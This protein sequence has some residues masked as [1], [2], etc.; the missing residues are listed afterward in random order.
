M[1]KHAFK[2]QGPI[3]GIT[4]SIGAGKTVVSSILKNKGFAVIN[5]DEVAKDIREKPEVAAQ[6][7]SEFGTSDA[8]ELRKVLGGN[9]EKS[10]KLSQIV[11]IPAL[12]ETFRRTNE[13]FAQGAK[14]V[15]W[16]AALLIDTGTY[17][18]LSGV[19]LVL[20]GEK[21]RTDRVIARDQVD[22]GYIKPILDQQMSDVEKI[23][24]LKLHPRHLILENNGTLSEFE[25][26]CLSLEPWIDLL[27][28]SKK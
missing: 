12:Q 16:E 27:L 9:L 1:F 23:K 17:A 5:F 2:S 28:S 19:I 11:A 22:L 15:F 21:T 26:K 14:V 3:I 10:Y 24:K 6:L 20:A 4:G 13:L 7:I 8:K 25:M 18:S